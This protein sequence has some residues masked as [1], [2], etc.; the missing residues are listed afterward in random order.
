M[1]QVLICI[2]DALL[3]IRI[4]KLMIQK[5]ISFDVTKNPI[6]KDDLLKY[7]I[8]MIHSSYRLSGLYSFIESIVLQRTIPIILISSNTYS[9]QFQ[10]LMKEPTFV[11]IEEMKMDAEIWLAV[12]LFKKQKLRVK[13]LE[14]NIKQLSSKYL[15]EKQMNQTKKCLIQQGYSEEE[16]HQMILKYA[17]DHKISKISACEKILMDI[18]QKDS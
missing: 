3:T 9:N 2:E 7:D 5:G 11:N 1:K 13:E 14:K 17:M 10:R 4:S 18:L 15:T 6:R 8:L 12:D 16:A